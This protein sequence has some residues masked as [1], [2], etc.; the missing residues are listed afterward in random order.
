VLRQYAPP[1][2]RYE[3]IRGRD[4]AVGTVPIGEIFRYAPTKA[5]RPRTYMVE[6]WLTR[7]Y[8]RADRTGRF[9]YLGRGGHLALVRDLANG[10]RAILADAIIRHCIDWPAAPDRRTA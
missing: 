4:L 10:R 1:R 2:H 8:A 5:A 3:T 6:A 9:S 7:A